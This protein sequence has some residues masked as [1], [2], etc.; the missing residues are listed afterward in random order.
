[1]ASIDINRDT[2]ERVKELLAKVAGVV[3]SEASRS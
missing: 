2:L 1:M 3:R